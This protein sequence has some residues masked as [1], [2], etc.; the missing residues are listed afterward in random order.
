MV[1]LFEF[2]AVEATGNRL[3]LNTTKRRVK[4]AALADA[5][6]Q[7]MMRDLV[8]DDQKAT[9][10]VIKDQVGHTLREVLANA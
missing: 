3:C 9:V 6:G 1:Y 4:T 10:C 5:Y 7:S 8:F 2:F